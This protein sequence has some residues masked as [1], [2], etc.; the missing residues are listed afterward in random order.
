MRQYETHYDFKTGEEYFSWPQI[1]ETFSQKTVKRGEITFSSCGEGFDEHGNLKAH[2]RIHTGESPSTCQQ[3]GKSFTQKRKLY[4]HMR[5]HTGEKPVCLQCGKSFYNQGNLKVHM[6]IH[7]EERPF[8]CQLCGVSFT[9]EGFLN[10]H[11]RIHKKKKNHRKAL[12]VPSVWKVSTEKETLTNMRIHTREKLYT[13]SQWREIRS[14][15][16]P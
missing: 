2:M 11:M 13:C 8:I 16:K 1:K 5:I 14:T 10:R 9:H 12:R 15:W 4:R 6:R 7:T 3:C